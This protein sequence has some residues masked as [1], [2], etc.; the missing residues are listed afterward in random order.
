M[1]SL[2][3]VTKTLNTEAARATVAMLKTMDLDDD[4]LAD[5][6]FG[7][8]LRPRRGPALEVAL[9]PL[10]AGTFGERLLRTLRFAALL[11]A[12]SVAP[13]CGFVP[14]AGGFLLVVVVHVAFALLRG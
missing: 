11:R 10:A 7:P 14:A 6:A 2:M 12:E 1:E 5:H 3:R 13:A 4:T 8:L 9:W